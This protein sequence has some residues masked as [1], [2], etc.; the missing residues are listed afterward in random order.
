MA[1]LIGALSHPTAL[2]ARVLSLADEWKE[3]PESTL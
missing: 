1:E 2:V 3:A